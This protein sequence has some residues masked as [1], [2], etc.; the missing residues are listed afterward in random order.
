MSN[1][2]AE[3][4]L[5][6]FTA[7]SSISIGSY[8]VLALSDISL[9]PGL[10][11]EK[12]HKRVSLISL[13][14]LF[15]AFLAATFH[16][17]SPLNAIYVMNGLGRSPLTNEVLV[18]GLFVV[19]AV[20]YT[21]FVYKSYEKLPKFLSVLVILGAIIFALFIGLAYK[22]ETIPSWTSP[23]S[24]I[25]IWGLML[26]SGVVLTA[27]VAGQFHELTDSQTNSRLRILALVGV[28]LA[29]ISVLV[30]AMQVNTLQ[31]GLF[32]GSSVVA[33]ALPF[34]VLALVLLIVSLV[35]FM[36]FSKKTNS[37]KALVLTCVVLG[38][39]IL[40]RMSFYALHMSAGLTV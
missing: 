20:I 31:N 38:A 24:F 35:L 30:Q 18:G 7:L 32:E 19:L 25:E 4:P 34:I 17:A 9:L 2:I 13:I 36:N 39:V 37:G 33:S 27:V 40:T 11:G 1:V 10:K 26:V 22:M 21:I 28:L 14:L 29:G 8:F 12:L 15:V 23:I 6:L 16:L 3:L 5:I